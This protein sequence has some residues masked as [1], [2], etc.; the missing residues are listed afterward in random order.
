MKN[1]IIGALMGSVATL[2]LT[3]QIE[4]IRVKKQQNEKGSSEKKDESSSEE[5]KEE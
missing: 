1:F 2:A 3:S 5:E 4:V